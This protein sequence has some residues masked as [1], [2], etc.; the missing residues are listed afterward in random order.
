MLHRQSDAA[1]APYGVTADQFVLMA[2]LSEGGAMT[3]KELANR[4]P[5]DP[6][7]VRAM[8]VLLEGRGLVRRERHPTDGRARMAALTKVG[9]RKFGQLWK[10]GDSIRGRAVAEMSSDD[11]CKLVQLL[12]QF[13]ES[14]DPNSVVPETVT[15]GWR[16]K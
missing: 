5:S 12:K 1:F 8:L 14:L 3:Q 9:R 6:S 11:A 7:T 13:T 4:M 2:R 16:Q 10:A 15:E